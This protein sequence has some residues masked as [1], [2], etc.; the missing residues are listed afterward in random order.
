MLH[1]LVIRVRIMTLKIELDFLMVDEA[2][3]QYLAS[4]SACLEEDKRGKH[5]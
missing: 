5:T 2:R 3:R 4:M 1:R